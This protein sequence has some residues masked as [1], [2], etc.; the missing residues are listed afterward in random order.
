MSLKHDW[1]DRPIVNY[2]VKVDAEVKK[3]K[4]SIGS[5]LKNL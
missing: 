2:T 4:S 5:Y 3:E 1:E